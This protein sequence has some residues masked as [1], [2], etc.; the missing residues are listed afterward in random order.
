MQSLGPRGLLILGQTPLVREQLLTSQRRLT[1][2]TARNCSVLIKH[3]QNV[4]VRVRV[5]FSHQSTTLLI[6]PLPI[7]SHL[8]ILGSSTLIHSLRILNP[9]HT[10]VQSSTV[11]T[12]SPN[13]CALASL[14][15]CPLPV[16]GFWIEPMLTTGVQPN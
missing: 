3:E 2:S 16:F 14:P 8:K 7:I 9:V 1:P 12:S 11:R 6:T 5:L 13:D 4:R 15:S 10:H